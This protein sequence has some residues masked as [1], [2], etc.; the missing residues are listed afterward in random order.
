MKKLSARPCVYVRA[1]DVHRLL[2]GMIATGKGIASA[3]WILPRFNEI[4][5]AWSPSPDDLWSVR[6]RTGT[7]NG[8]Y[9]RRFHISLLFSGLTLFYLCHLRN[10]LAPEK[11]WQTHLG[12]AWLIYFPSVM[13]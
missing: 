6:I 11:S 3:D 4:L 2:V 7:E 8:L 1:G 5:F 13:N 12:F 10:A 9:R